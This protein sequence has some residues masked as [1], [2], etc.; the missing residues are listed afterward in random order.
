LGIV[1]NVNLCPNQPAHHMRTT[2]LSLPI[3]L[4]SRKPQVQFSLLHPLSLVTMELG[5]ARTLSPGCRT[6]R[7]CR[8]AEGAVARSLTVGR[9]RTPVGRCRTLSD[10]VRRCRTCRTVRLSDCCHYIVGHYCGVTYTR[11][12]RTAPFNVVL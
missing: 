11:G 10:A 3:P 1:F 6:C 9:C 8:T 4:P 12:V 2:L 7:T 5:A